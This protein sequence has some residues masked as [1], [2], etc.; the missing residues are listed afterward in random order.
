MRLFRRH[1]APFVALWLA[2]CHAAAVPPPVAITI[3]TGGTG[4]VYFPLGDTLAR[5]FTEQIPGVTVSAI[6][7][8]ASV[9]NMQAI[10]AG[11]ADLAFTQG[12]VAYLAY[13]AGTAKHPRPHGNLR[14][15]AVLY[16]NAVQVVTRA[17]SGI[18]RMQDLRGRRVGVGAAGSGTEIAAR[19]IIEASGLRYDE[20]HANDLG[21]AE[22][23]AHL[24]NRTLDVGFLVSSYPVAALADAT[25]TMGLRL[26]PVDP[27]A[28]AR[29]RETYPF[30]KP[31]T[32]PRGTYRGQDSDVPTIGV[33]NLLV[34][35]A[36]LSDEVVHQMTRVL[37]ESLPTLTRA[38]VA[39]R[40]IDLD[41]A[42][43]TPIPLH[44]GAARYYRE[45]EL[46]R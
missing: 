12:D 43:A 13:T 45:L 5:R 39:A 6:A 36:G 21:F 1:A 7:T 42:P 24:K 41:Q 9:F 27:D 4:G 26:V 37:I 28:A 10:E 11:R 14:G 25:E 29:I 22:T 15:L 2:A 34:V 18:H 38:H 40:G 44:P 46:I 17:G 35:R 33:D 16:V 8:V 20:V 3:A 31:V 19:I 30:F 32:I 23:A